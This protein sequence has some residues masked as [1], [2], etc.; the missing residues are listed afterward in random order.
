MYTTCHPC[1]THIE[2]STM[3]PVLKGLLVYFLNSF[4]YLRTLNDLANKTR[5]TEE[6]LCSFCR[7]CASATPMDNR[8][9][10]GSEH[11]AAKRKIHASVGNL[12][13]IVPPVSCRYTD[14]VSLDRKNLFGCNRRTICCL[15]RLQKMLKSNNRMWS[16]IASHTGS[17][18]LRKCHFKS[19]DD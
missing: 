1:V 14:C 7:R 16:A 19:N 2:V 13:A 15:R 5:F 8:V 3:F 4:V 17:G 6:C 10:S 9:L 12:T 11:M 18:S